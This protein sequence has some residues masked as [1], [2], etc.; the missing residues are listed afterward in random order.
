[1][2]SGAWG[3]VQEG[4]L[5][6]LPHVLDK[7]PDVVCVGPSIQTGLDS[8]KIQGVC[9]FGSVVRVQLG[10]HWLDEWI[11]KL[12]EAHATVSLMPRKATWP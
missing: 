12:Q 4:I 10:V 7:G 11:C 2:N 1:M 9:D 6:D 5:E 8:A 3:I